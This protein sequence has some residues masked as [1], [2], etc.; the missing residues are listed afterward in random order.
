MRHLMGSVV[1]KEPTL[2]H[3]YRRAAPER[4]QIDGQ[5]ESSQWQ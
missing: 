5:A 2:L 1:M 4:E 3:L